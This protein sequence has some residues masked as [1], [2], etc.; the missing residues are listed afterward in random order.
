M[1]ALAE[2]PDVTDAHY[3][4]ATAADALGEVDR[5]L[6]EFELFLKLA[7]PSSMTAYAQQ[8]QAALRTQR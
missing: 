8:R 1:R 5:A 4:V 2:D 7:S 3:G 6:A